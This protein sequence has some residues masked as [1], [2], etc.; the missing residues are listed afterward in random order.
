MV[1]I[2]LALKGFFLFFLAGDI[3]L[4]FSCASPVDQK[5]SAEQVSTAR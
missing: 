4:S 3:L 5:A 2:L 1:R